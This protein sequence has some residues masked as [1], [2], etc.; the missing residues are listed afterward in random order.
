MSVT[1]KKG[2]LRREAGWYTIVDP[3]GKTIEG[4]T[5]FCVHCGGHFLGHPGSG[6][7]RGFCQ[8]CNG[9]VCGIQCARCQYFEQGIENIEHGR[10]W[11][12]K[13]IVVSVSA[14]P[15]GTELSP[16]GV[17]VDV[18]MLPAPEASGTS[19]GVCSEGGVLLGSA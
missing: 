6:T 1:E 9:Y 2:Q 5:Y 3:D 15:P 11:Y 14:A 19:G 17:L 13:P 18:P 12:F 4:R 16:G 8:H 10:D 7:L